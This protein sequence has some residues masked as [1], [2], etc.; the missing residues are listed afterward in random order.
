[1]ARV[2]SKVAQE[3]IVLQVGE[4]GVPAAVSSVTFAWNS[5][6]R[7]ELGTG[8]AGPGSTGLRGLSRPGAGVA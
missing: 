6:A 2:A 4:S 8:A 3:G 7:R 1:M 5:A